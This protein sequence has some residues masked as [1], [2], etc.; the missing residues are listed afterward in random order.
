[1]KDEFDN[2]KNCNM[3]YTQSFLIEYSQYDSAL[4]ETEKKVRRMTEISKQ[5]ATQQTMIAS[6]IEKN[7]EAETTLEITPVAKTPEENLDL[8]VTWN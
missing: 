8:I 1:M 6:L 5:I 7:E 4:Q 3:V 2:E